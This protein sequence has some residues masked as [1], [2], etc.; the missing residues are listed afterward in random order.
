VHIAYL[1]SLD[2]YF[3]VWKWWIW[4]GLRAVPAPCRVGVWEL[5]CKIQWR[6]Y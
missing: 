2:V 4:T 6:F 3:S 5:F 1:N